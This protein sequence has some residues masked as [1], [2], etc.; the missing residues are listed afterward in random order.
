[1]GERER[2]KKNGKREKGEGE[3]DF[4]SN[5]VQRISSIGHINQHCHVWGTTQKNQVGQKQNKLFFHQNFWNG[6]KIGSTQLIEAFSA[7]MDFDINK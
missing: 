4:M 7:L 3:R 2:E 1:M 5:L 6:K